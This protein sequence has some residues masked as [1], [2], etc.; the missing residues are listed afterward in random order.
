MTRKDYELIAK[1]LGKALVCSKDYGGRIPAWIDGHRE[2]T[3]AIS[4]ALA[5]DN[6]RFN[7]VKF[8][9]AIYGEGWE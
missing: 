9:D 5:E 3:H 1:A 8:L 4:S 2:A 6:D 7:E